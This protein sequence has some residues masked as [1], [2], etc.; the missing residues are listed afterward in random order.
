MARTPASLSSQELRAYRK[1]LK[2]RRRLVEAHAQT[3]LKQAWDVAHRAARIL[4]DEFGV[5]K[6]VVFG[7]LLHPSTFHSRSDVDL[8]TWGLTGREYYR[9]VGILQSL[10]PTNG[11]DLV[12]FEDASPGVRDAI[13][14]E[15]VEL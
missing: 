15:G 9:A 3:R 5:E 4:R 1:A 6:V 8:A 11:V 7:S 10:D 2:A 13:R 14:A 12:A